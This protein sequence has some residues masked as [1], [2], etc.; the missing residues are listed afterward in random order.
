[1]SGGSLIL[2]CCI[3]RSRGQNCRSSS[4]PCSPGDEVVKIRCRALLAVRAPPLEVEQV[5]EPDI[6][7]K[8]S[9]QSESKRGVCMPFHRCTSASPLAAHSSLQYRRRLAGNAPPHTTHLCILASVSR[10]AS[11]CQGEAVPEAGTGART[12]AAPPRAEQEDA[13]ERSTSVSANNDRYA[14]PKRVC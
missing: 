11:L 10:L 8:R 4:R 12:R 9:R 3:L 2:Q 6:D 1:M 5:R 13:L 7:V 14:D